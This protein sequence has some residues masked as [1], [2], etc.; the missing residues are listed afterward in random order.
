VGLTKEKSEL[1]CSRLKEKS[2]LAFGATFSW[3]RNC[4]KEF[5][6]YYTNE[7]QL[8]FCCDTPNLVHQLG[9]V[10]YDTSDWRLF[11]DCSKSSLKAV[12]LHNSNNL[13]SIP[14]AHSIY[15]KETYENLRIVL[16]KMKYHECSWYL[17]SDM[18]ILG[19]LLG[20]HGRYTKFPCFLC[21]WDSR[22]TDKH[23]TTKDLPK[24]ENLIPG[25]KNVH[26]S[27]VDKQKFYYLPCP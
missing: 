1:L 13:A 17:C 24:R 6:K 5:Q 9:T 2:L 3:Y 18:K 27:L 22:A 7:D 4:E 12:L 16:E 8:L 10:S 23:W 11:I 21:E 20:Q 26:A 19:M 15:L 14:I 25:S